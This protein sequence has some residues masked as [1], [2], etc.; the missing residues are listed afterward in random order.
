[1]RA[2]GVRGG[3]QRLGRDGDECG[4]EDGDKDRNEDRGRQEDEDRG[5]GEGE[6]DRKD[7]E[8]TGEWETKALEGS[9]VGCGFHCIGSVVFN[10][11]VLF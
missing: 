8:Q 10:V 7:G 4:D 9:F 1:M 3:P 5:E 11:L 2:I 6:G